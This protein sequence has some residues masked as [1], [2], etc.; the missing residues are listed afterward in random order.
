MIL[1]SSMFFLGSWHTS[2]FVSRWKKLSPVSPSCDVP[3]W[4][5]KDPWSRRL[6]Q[7]VTTHGHPFLGEIPG[8]QQA[9][10][11]LNAA[12]ARPKCP[13]IARVFAEEANNK[14]IFPLFFSKMLICRSDQ[15]GPLYQPILETSS[16]SY[17]DLKD[18]FFEQLPNDSPLKNLDIKVCWPKIWDRIQLYSQVRLLWFAWN[19]QWI[20]FHQE[21]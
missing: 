7:T 15:S 9:G 1:Q 17:T 14:L 5:A 2:P 16:A 20:P 4:N 8:N 11:W 6:H 3:H 18:M 12:L 10:G 19:L 21:S 13:G